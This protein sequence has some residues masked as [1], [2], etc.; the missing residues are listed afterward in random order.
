MNCLCPHHLQFPDHVC[1][2]TNSHEELL[3]AA[4]GALVELRFI[5]QSEVW[6]PVEKALQ[7]A[8]AQAKHQSDFDCARIGYVLALIITAFGIGLYVG[9]V[10]FR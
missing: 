2:C 7:K 5:N 3:E 10:I 1:P 4:K 9:K 6:S 8:I